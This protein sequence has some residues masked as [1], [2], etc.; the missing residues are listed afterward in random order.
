[1]Y[2]YVY[3]SSTESDLPQWKL[4]EIFS[5]ARIGTGWRGRGTATARWVRSVVDR[6][7]FDGPEALVALLLVVAA[8]L[9]RGDVGCSFLMMMM[10]MIR[11]RRR[12]PSGIREMR[13]DEIAQVGRH[14]ER[15]R[16]ALT[17]L[18]VDAACRAALVVARRRRSA[19]VGRAA[20][21]GGRDVGVGRAGAHHPSRRTSS[22]SEH[23]STEDA[24]IRRCWNTKSVS[25][26]RG[27]PGARPLRD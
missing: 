5:P 20:V 11:T 10:M 17:P 23:V 8:D 16:L 27:M 15:S 7:A 26:A 4:V 21:S 13:D 12:V 1:M 24:L 25:Q 18:S 6:V 19:V 2:V 9:D 22:G 3:V 14:R